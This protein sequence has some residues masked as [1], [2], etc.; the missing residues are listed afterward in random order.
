MKTLNLKVADEDHAAYVKT[1]AIARASMATWIRMTLFE[2][3][4]ANLEKGALGA[5]IEKEKPRPQTAEEKRAAKAEAYTA[6]HLK[7]RTLAGSVPFESG[8]AR[9][10]GC[11]I[12]DEGENAAYEAEVRRQ[13]A[14]GAVWMEDRRAPQAP[15]NLW[16]QYQ[17]ERNAR[18]AA[19]AREA[20]PAMTALERT[21]ANARRTP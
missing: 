3:A 4:K 10:R 18:E 15:S 19:E 7:N 16:R 9:Y 5:V 2:A 8:Q 12:D 14:G 1:A 17:H 6:M 13:G 20:R 21:F 11:R